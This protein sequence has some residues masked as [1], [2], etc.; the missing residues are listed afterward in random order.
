MPWTKR[1]KYPKGDLHYCH[2]P[3][4]RGCTRKLAVGSEW[5]CRK[6]K[7]V[8]RL[9][10]V[11]RGEDGRNTYMNWICEKASEGKYQDTSY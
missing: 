11:R 3:E 4:V 6:C 8:W 7:A 1:V 10:K 2:L 5:K 9:Q